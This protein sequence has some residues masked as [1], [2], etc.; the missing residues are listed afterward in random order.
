MGSIPVTGIVTFQA[1]RISE[2][3]EARTRGKLDFKGR[4]LTTTK[5]FSYG[6]GDANYFE[7]QLESLLAYFN[8]LMVA[9]QSQEEEEDYV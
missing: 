1:K 3:I 5:P 9:Y 8:K 2:K 7:P 4:L 6:A